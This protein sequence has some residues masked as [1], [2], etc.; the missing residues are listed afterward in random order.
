MGLQI[1]K[2]N[3]IKANEQ[4]IRRAIDQ[5]AAV[6]A[7]FLLTP[8]GSLSGYHPNFDRAAVAD[9]VQRVA[10][11]A[12]KARVG[13]LLGTCYKEMEDDRA[14]SPVKRSEGPGTL[15]EYCYDQVRVYAP[16]GE[17]LGAHSKILLCTPLHHPGTGEMREY[18]TGKLRTYSWGGICFGVLICNDLW[19]TPGYTSTPNPYLAWQLKEM[20]AQVIFQAVG[21]AG[22]PVLYRAYHESNQMLW[23]MALGIPIVTTNAT[24]GTTPS[25]CRAGVVGADGERVCIAQDVGEQFFSYKLSAGCSPAEPAS[26]SPARLIFQRQ[27][28]LAKKFPA[29]GNLSLF[30]LSQE[31]G[32]V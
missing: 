2:S 5:A 9:A 25:A 15:R 8:E 29:N 16:D 3:D 6:K 23:A 19:A 21:T 28:P 14:G 32:S 24:D 13:L 27:H 22:A 20:G 4:A 17:Y 26:A 31:R 7:D 11:H 12:K 18:V 30:S 10:E 1:L